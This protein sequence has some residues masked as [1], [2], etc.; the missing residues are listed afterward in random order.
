MIAL[1]HYLAEA[2]RMP[3]GWGGPGRVDCCTYA[4]G[5]VMRCGYPDPMAFIRGTYNSE[6]SALRCIRRGGG[7]VPLWTRGMID[8]QVPE[9]DQARIGD[10]GILRLPT[11]DGGDE[12]V[13]L[14][15]GR[16]WVCRLYRGIVSLPADS[17][18]VW[19]PTPW[20]A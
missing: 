13:G 4:A 8:A 5:W 12:C 11:E 3:W 16:R 9:A 10:V 7:L 17:L 15:A 14:F 19:R 20:V 18:A 2:A 1:A 6:R